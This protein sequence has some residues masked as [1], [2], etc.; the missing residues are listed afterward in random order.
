[1]DSLSKSLYSV[2]SQAVDEFSQ[3]VATKYKVPKEE[4]LELWNSHVSSEL[5]VVETASKPPAKDK[6]Q[7]AA[8]P[9][10]TADSCGSAMCSYEFK[11]GKNQGTS[12]TAKVC[13]ESSKFCRKHKEQ[14]GKENGEG[15]K[16]VKKPSASKAKKGSDNKEKDTPAVKKMTDGKAGYVAIRNVQGNYEHPETKFV[17]HKDTKEVYGRQTDNGVEDLTPDEIEQCK[18]LN[19]KCRMP[20]TLVSKKDS[21]KEEDDEDAEELD[22]NLDEDDEEEDEEEDEDEDEDEN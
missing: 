9:V 1:M 10:N 6:K 5:K 22:E 14:D 4:V 17:F 8:R 11:K 21:S 16:P 3:A 18:K 13:S 12:C 2:V 7:A 20:T 19:F 15:D